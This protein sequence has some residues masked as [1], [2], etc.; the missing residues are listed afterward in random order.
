MG[1]YG[2]VLGEPYGCARRSSVEDG[3]DPVALVHRLRRC[4]LQHPVQ[5]LPERRSRAGD[6]PR[7]YADGRAC[8]GRS[9][10]DGDPRP[11][12]PTAAATQEPAARRSRPRRLP[13]G[14]RRQPMQGAATAE[15]ATGA[16]TSRGGG[17]SIQACCTALHGGRHQVGQVAGSQV[18]GGDG[19]ASLRRDREAR[20]ERENPARQGAHPD[21]ASLA[22]TTA[23]AECN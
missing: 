4:C 22:G 18:E 23:P 17:A 2:L 14:L 13:P 5:L 19:I 11:L 16:T 6:D 20:E 21:R 8:G 10:A 3:H 9:G 7:A 12:R 1:P 15:G